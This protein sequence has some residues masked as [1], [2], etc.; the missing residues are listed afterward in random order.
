MSRA[1]RAA[2]AGLVLALLGACLTLRKPEITF[3]GVSIGSANRDRA[4]LDVVL[5]VTNPNGYLLG[6]RELTYRLTIGGIAAGEGSIDSDVSVPAHG[7][8]TVHLPLTVALAP[9]KASAFAMALSGGIDY[10]VDGEVVFTTPLG[11]VRRPYRHE[12]RLSLFR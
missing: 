11:K 2:A 7:S 4:A 12:D 8:A 5:G 1:R 10:A 9:L 3:Q 6:V